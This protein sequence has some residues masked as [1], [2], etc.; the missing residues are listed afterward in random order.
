MPAECPPARRYHPGIPGDIISESAGDFAGICILVGQ[1]AL[2]IA[3]KGSRARR[4]W[5]KL[6]EWLIRN[7]G[8]SESVLNAPSCVQ[9]RASGPLTDIYVDGDACP[10]REGIYRVAMRL[11]L[12]VFVVSNGSRSLIAL[13]TALQAACERQRQAESVMH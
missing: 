12:N 6:L 1:K 4:R 2:A 3:V 13:D 10:V 8:L 11:R 9:D 7:G 5:S